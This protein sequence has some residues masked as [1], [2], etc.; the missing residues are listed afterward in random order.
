MC[1]TVDGVHTIHEERRLEKLHPKYGRQVFI[2]TLYNSFS[3]S[4]V[5]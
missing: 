1:I 3:E 2:T 4:S 5:V